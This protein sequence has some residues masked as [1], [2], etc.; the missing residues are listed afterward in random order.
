[1]TPR[2][3]MAKVESKRLEIKYAEI[4]SNYLLM[5]ASSRV[6]KKVYQEFALNKAKELIKLADEPK[7]I[8]EIST[9]FSTI[10]NEAALIIS[11]YNNT[12][13]NMYLYGSYE[14]TMKSIEYNKKEPD[15]QKVVYTICLEKARSI[16]ESDKDLD[17]NDALLL[18]HDDV[19]DLINLLFGKADESGRIIESIKKRDLEH[20]GNY[21][22]YLATTHNK[23][24]LFHIW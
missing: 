13:N 15:K 23:C 2:T 11:H 24:L 8:K 20:L 19:Y 9:F 10:L 1:M 17:T 6:N 5:Q 22:Q 4:I 14:E 18:H 21:G 3:Q 16:L 7:I 12:H